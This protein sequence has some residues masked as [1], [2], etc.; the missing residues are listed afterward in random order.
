MPRPVQSPPTGKGLLLRLR[1][2]IAD[3]RGV[4]AIEF[5]IVAPLLVLTYVGAF[6]ITVG[7]TVARKVSR[8]SS[9]VSDLLTRG[10]TTTIAKLDAMK[11]VTKSVVAP[12]SQN[13]YSLKM[14]GIAIDADGKATVAWSRGWSRSAGS[15]TEVLNNSPYT[16]GDA[17]T[18]PKNVEA[19][20]SFIVRT[21][22]QMQHPIL[23]MAPSLASRVKQIT[24]SKDSY[25]RLRKGTKITCG[26]C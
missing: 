13:E 8:A 5:A 20:N 25:F 17:V 11:D 4:G 24:L 12:F 18:L 19:K 23:L 3:R 21:E 14:T 1:R 26:D 6:E 7:V 9:N 22:F 2:L 16:K 15:S 10:D